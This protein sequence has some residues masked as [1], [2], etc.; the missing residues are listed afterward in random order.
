M[1]YQ[2]NPKQTKNDPHFLAHVSRSGLLAPQEKRLYHPWNMLQMFATLCFL[3]HLEVVYYRSNPTA[4]LLGKQK[5]Y[6]CLRI[7][8][9]QWG[10]LGGEEA[11]GAVVVIVRL[12]LELTWCREAAMAKSTTGTIHAIHFSI[13]LVL[14]V[15]FLLPSHRDFA[16]VASLRR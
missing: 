1:K 7:K 2:P 4:L 15:W 16:D 14:S 10:N 8:A 11:G 3:L 6:Y 12:P 13:A 9:N 5:Q